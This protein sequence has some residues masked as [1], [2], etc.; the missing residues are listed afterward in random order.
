[1]SLTTIKPGMRE[2]DVANDLD[3]FMRG[4][5]ASNV[6]LKRLSLPGRAQ[7]CPMGAATEKKIEKRRYYHA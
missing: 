4:L 2:I 6:S 3:F 7:R 1:M 5:G